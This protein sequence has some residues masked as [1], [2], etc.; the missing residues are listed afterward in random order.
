[1]L[2]HILRHIEADQGVLAAEQGGGQGAAQLRLAHPRGA[3]KQEHP[4]GAVGLL[5]PHPAAADG[6][7]YGG[8]RLLLPHHPAVELS[9]QLQQPFGLPLGDGLQGD[10]RPLGQHRRHVLPAE[11]PGGGALLPGLLPV[12]LPAEVGLRVPEHGGP[13]KVLHGDGLGL[14][15]G[16]PLRPVGQG[17][18]G[19]GHFLLHPQAGRPLV[20]EVDGLVRQVAVG[21]IPPGQLHRRVDGPVG[22]GQ[23]VVLLIPAAQAPEDGLGLLRGGLRHLHRLEPPLQGGVLLDIL[24]VLLQGGGPHHLDLPPAQGGL[25][26][27]GGVDGPLGGPGPHDVV[28]LVQEQDHVSRPSDL[29]QHLVHPLLKLPPVLGARHHG[30][31]IQAEQPLAPQG[32]GHRPGG[33]AQGQPLRHRRLAHPRLADEGGVVLGAAGQ[34][35]DHPAHLPLP[36]HQGVQVPQGR[37]PGEIPGEPVGKAGIPALG[38]GPLL[39]AGGLGIAP[40]PPQPVPGGLLLFPIHHKKTSQTLKKS[41]PFH[42][43]QLLFHLSFFGEDGNFQR[44]LYLLPY[45]KFHIAISGRCDTIGT[46]QT[47]SAFGGVCYMA[48]VI[49]D[50]CIS[51]GACEGSCPVG[52]ISMG[53][54]HMKIDAAACIDCGAC[55]GTCP[56]GAIAAE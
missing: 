7:G 51:C 37:Q 46:V 31:Q 44:E 6:G 36:A 10:A 38:A 32:L 34:D 43:P 50:T 24:A 35:L 42:M 14:L 54:D 12:Q 9:L 30:H 28:Q 5:Q 20:D 16:R 29:R 41:K 22:D 21:Q 18:E 47:H 15:P 13:L 3:Q 56:M 2:L 53:D 1:M 33:H 4:D 45:Q 19:H 49:N 26:D 25:E 8:H 27:V 11:L 52:A 23:A 40:G 39:P 17:P 48:R 55:E